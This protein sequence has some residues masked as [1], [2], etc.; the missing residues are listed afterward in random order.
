MKINAYQLEEKDNIVS[1]IKLQV[2]Q[3]SI[4]KTCNNVVL[5]INQQIQLFVPLPLIR[6]VILILR[7]RNVYSIIVKMKKIM[8]G[9]IIIYL[10]IN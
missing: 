2:V 8:F 7:Q 4:I 3:S 1:L 6:H 10:I 5:L 9:M